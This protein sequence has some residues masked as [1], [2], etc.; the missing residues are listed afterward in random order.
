MPCQTATSKPGMV[1]ATGGVSGNCFIGAGVWL[2]E[3]AMLKA[4][5]TKIL[6]FPDTFLA[7]EDDLLAKGLSFVP[8]GALKRVPADSNR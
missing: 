2:A 6:A 5:R 8:E 7:I 1:F 4:L 3:P